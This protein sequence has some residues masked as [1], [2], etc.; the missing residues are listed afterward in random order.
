[1]GKVHSNGNGRDT[2]TQSEHALRASELR[3]RRLFEAAQDGILILDAD[4]GCITDVNPFLVN[5]LGFSHSEMVGKTVG[6]LSPFKDVA[7]HQAMLERLQKDGHVRHE[8]LPLETRDGRHIAV[9][10]VSNVYLA[11]DKNVIQC[12]IRDITERR[13]METALIHFRSIVESS[14]DAIMGKDL[15]GIITSWNRGAE[16]IFGYTAAEMVGTSIMR[17][18]PDD[19]RE[20]ENEILE[21]IQRGDSLDN[22]ETLRQTKGGRLIHVSITVCP[23]K[24]ASGKVIGVSKVVHDITVRKEHEIEIERLSRLYDALS[25]IN[26]AIV[27]LKNR[28]DLFTKICRVL[29]ETGK[30]QMAWVGWLNAQT[31]QVIQVAQYGDRQNYLSQITVYADDRP[32]GWGP[33]GTAIREGRNYIC[34]DFKHDPATLLWRAAAGQAGIQSSACFLIRQGGVICGAVT[35]YAGETDFFQDKEIK[36]LEEAATDV[37]FALDNFTREAARRQAEEDLRWKTAF[38]EAQVD[39]SLDGILVVD[40]RGKKIL[41][42]ERMNELWKIPPEV[43]RDT[44]DSVQVKFVTDRTKNPQQFADKVVHL[45]R[46]PDEVSRDEVELLDGTILDR[47]SSPVRDQAGKHYGR[48]WTFRD[49]TERKRI[50]A[51]FRRLVDSNAQGVIFWNTSGQITEANDAFLNLVGYTRA[52]L[53]A[54]PLDWPAMTPP[55]YADLDRQALKQIADTGICAPFEKEFISKDGRRV[56]ILIGAAAFD[57]A[58][59]EGVCFVIDLT[60]RKKLEDQFRQAQKMESFGQLAG[61]VAHDFNNILAVIQMQ[62]GLFKADGRLSPEQLECANEIGVSIGRAAALTRQLLLFSRKEVVQLRDL[63]LNQSINGMSNMLSRILGEDIQV[64]FRFSLQPL[65]IRADAGMVDQVLM[66]LAVNSRDAM[67]KGGL[68]IIETSAVNFGRP[69]SVP[70]PQ[71]RAGAFVCLSVSDNGCGIPAANLTRIFEPFF[72]T[73]P[74]GKGTGLGLATLF[75]IVQQHKGWVN[76]ESEVGRGT[77]FRIYL[78]RLDK[79]LPAL[80]KVERAKL[81]TLPGGNETILL[82]EDDDFL[83]PSV[84]NTLLR[85]GYHVIPVSNGIKALEIWQGRSDEI[86]MLIT[87]LVMPGGMTG[88]SLGELLLKQK[89][90]LQVIYAS[91]YS[92]E[93]AGTDFPLKEGVNFLTKPFQ[94]EKLARTIRDRFDNEA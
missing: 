70:P 74:V 63:D 21:K 58:P 8:N 85:L 19:R 78:P 25:H 73:K 53:A 41:Q 28:E 52:D 12:N 7:S 26:Q 29:V 60:E 71:G 88:K 59:H 56:P 77:T 82:V 81:S 44:D 51:R 86:E 14:D 66:N 94:T 36:L 11:G 40:N 17:L 50:E 33:T 92:A 43:A 42:N 93:I 84:C 27:N 68:L 69:G 87:D 91:G 23:I 37:S 46:H 10:F 49:T 64:Q 22:L 38:L 34:N 61:G 24:D 79:I 75:G 13:R 47:Y 83:R 80:P 15:D 90:K 31:H 45:N 20:E 67:P 55:G 39:C 2:G 16:K 48:I 4:T 72:T 5:L 62:V 30:L 65:G 3:Y 76:V 89:P 32:E 1:M 6:A 54:G 35:V 18:I 57:D 9:E